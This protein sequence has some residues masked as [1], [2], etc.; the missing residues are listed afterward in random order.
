MGIGV[1]T[2]NEVFYV[3]MMPIIRVNKKEV[4]ECKK[5]LFFSRRVHSGNVGNT[6]QLA[7][8]TRGSTFRDVCSDVE[9]SAP[10]SLRYQKSW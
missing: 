9:A 3:Y 4:H 1:E 2:F 6:S 8:R 7:N 5:K 10:F